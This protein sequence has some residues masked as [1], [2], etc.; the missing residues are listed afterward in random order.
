MQCERGTAAARPHLTNCQ[1]NA[2]AVIE[3]A[4]MAS[5]TPSDALTIESA[6]GCG[7]ARFLL[8]DKHL[9]RGGCRIHE[10]CRGPHASLALQARVL[11]QAAQRP[12][13][14]P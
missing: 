12:L 7:G 14:S 10:L 5:G 3:P 11:I 4:A 1:F 6:L 9:G 8:N 13:A 2:S